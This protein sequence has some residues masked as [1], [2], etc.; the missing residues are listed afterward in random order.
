MDYKDPISAA[1]DILNRDLL[2]EIVVDETVETDDSL[3][4]EDAEE[5]TNEASA[6]ETPTVDVIIN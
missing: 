3:V 5:E 1:K 6:S 2:E 4:V